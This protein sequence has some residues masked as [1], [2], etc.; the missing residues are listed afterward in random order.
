MA[1]QHLLLS[2]LLRSLPF[3]LLCGCSSVPPLPDGG[4]PGIVA[5]DPVP[6]EGAKT[7]GPPSW[8]VGDRFALL[9]GGQQRIDLTVTASENGSYT[10][11]DASGNRMRRGH[12][13]SN[14]GEWGREGDQAL[15]EL[16][17]ADVRFHWPVWIGKRWR[18][19]YSDRTAGGAAL[20]IET[21][22]EV[23]DLD[24]VVTP[25]GTFSALRIVRT[26]RLKLE[27]GGFLDRVS[28]VWYAPELGLE[29]RQI[30]G[31]TSVELLE[32]V[33]PSASE[34]KAAEVLPPAAATKQ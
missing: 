1:R 14:L 34:A 3:A 25:G 33:R 16:T 5:F 30:L 19:Q 31:D 13:L 4:G 20:P 18:C 28:V 21:G 15:H 27:G 2:L 8:Q 29:V 11:T 32:W 10:L 17:P 23:E 9:R 6:P 24:T 22:Y 26:S 12:D 7:W